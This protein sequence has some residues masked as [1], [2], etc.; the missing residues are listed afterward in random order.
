[1]HT[2]GKLKIHDMNN[3][4]LWISKLISTSSV[5][6][7]YL[8]LQNDGN[9]VIYDAEIKFYWSVWSGLSNSKLGVYLINYWPMSNLTDLISGS[10]LFGGSSYS[11][12]FDRFNSSNS[13]IYFNQGYL[14]VP[15]S[16][17]FSGD[18][19]FTAW[20]YLKSYKNNSRFFDF[21]DGKSSNNI[22]LAMSGLTSQIYGFILKDSSVLQIE[23]SSIINLNQWYFISFVLGG[24]TGCIYVNGIQVATGTLNLPNN[25]QRT[26]N[27][28]GKSNWATDFN[29]DAIYDEFKIYQ[30]ALSS[31]DIMN[32]Y[33]ISSNNGKLYNK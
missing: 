19:T 23:T 1:M 3:N 27:F 24:T 5:G 10:N 25:L 11:F 14:Q 29:A 17:Y 15:S 33:Q 7:Y 22:G 32:E 28:I 4:S 12:T 13:A 18:F 30:G 16:V 8:K 31:S 6:G 26:S 21:G 9:L 20:I 2:N